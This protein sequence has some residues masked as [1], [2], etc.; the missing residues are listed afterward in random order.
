MNLLHATL[1]LADRHLFHDMGAGFRE[2]QQR[3]DASDLLLWILLPV[4]FFVVVGVL[5]RL[6]S[7]GDNRQ[8]FNSPRRLF[9]ALCRAHHLERPE[10]SLLAQ[11]AKAEGIDQPARLFLDPDCFQRATIHPALEGKQSAI[12]ALTDRL[13]PSAAAPSPETP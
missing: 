8:L 1:L 7:R 10:R 4:A 11:I 12:A 3:F 6:L 13:F 5:A 9:H 2:K